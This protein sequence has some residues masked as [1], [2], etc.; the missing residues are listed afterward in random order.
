[1]RLIAALFL[2][3]IPLFLLSIPLAAFQD[4]QPKPAKAP[5]RT[6]GT[7]KFIQVKYL[8][9]DRVARVIQL[10]QQLYGGRVR[11]AMDP[12][13]DA[14]ALQ[15]DNVADFEPVEELIRKFD[16]PPAQAPERQI[17]L[18]VYMLEAVPAEY[19]TASRKAPPELAGAVEQLAT[20]FGDKH[21]IVA[22]TTILLARN[23]AGL[24][25]SGMLARPAADAPRAPYTVKCRR[26]G[27]DEQTKNVYVYG[28]KYLVQV[29][30]GAGFSDS[31]LET[32]LVI[33]EGQKL[34][35]GKVTKGQNNNNGYI[36]VT[37]KAE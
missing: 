32:D 31:A 28:F 5:V 37:A 16:V 20:V 19:A 24:T 30:N 27:Y 33:K 34:V 21:F 17:R 36:V 3:S 13:L 14:F 22:E 29:P 7:V 23:G 11:I 10:A 9:G 25:T 15:A 1:M 18:T 12:V 6:T 35:I 26:V 4:K 2:L 8:K